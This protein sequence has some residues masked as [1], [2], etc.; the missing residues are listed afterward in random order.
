M[1]EVD[2]AIYPRANQNSLMDTLATIQSVRNAREQN[3][4]LQLEQQRQTIGVTQ[5]QVNL[6]HQ[7]YGILSGAL[8]TLAQDPRIA[9][10]DGM[11]LLKQTTDQ[12]VKTGIID[13]G[14]ADAELAN[15]PHDPTQLPQYLQTL[16]TRV[17]GAQ[18]KFGQIYGTPGTIENGSVIQP[19]TSSPIT[20]VRPIA[21]PIQRTL[22]PETRADLVPTTNAHGQ[23]VMV[24]KGNLLTQAGMNPMTAQPQP[25]GNMLAPPQGSPQTFSQPGQ[26]Q[27][28]G[29]VTSPP[30]GEVEAQ[31]R[32][33]AASSDKYSAD[34]QREANFQND[35]LPLN[36]AYA[37][38]KA[39]GT[40][41]TGPGTETLNDVKSFLV[42]QGVIG[43][44]EDVKNF[45]EV[46]KYTTQLARQNGDTG[47]DSR[48]A[49]SFA[50]NP[51]VNISNAAAQDVLKSAISL[52]RLQNAQVQS[53]AQSNASPSKYQQYG[54]QFSKDQDPVAYGFDLMEPAQRLKYFQGLDAAGKAR[55]INSLKTA[56]SFGLVNQPQTQQQ[57]NQ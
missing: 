2:T 17:L 10:P 54:V 26:P 31:T 29:V 49:A 16:N 22:S 53:F 37:G 44:N 19:V 6:A 5:D 51:S 55:F 35:M 12:L 50:G 34:Q 7:R 3:K 46:R 52:R 57:G 24:P 18:E 47:S 33:A 39:L 23:Q 41:G 14:T 32:Q 11:G 15:A 20:G 27:G 21:G 4:L 36:K 48:L 28:G 40:T 9:T 42:S 1:A 56:T 25:Q 30:A 45:D 43:P 8:G 13:Q 38:M